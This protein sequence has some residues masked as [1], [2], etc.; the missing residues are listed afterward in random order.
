ML[1]MEMAGP[2][3]VN[4]TSIGV[5]A[6]PFDVTENVMESDVSVVG[7]RPDPLNVI[8][9]GLSGAPSVIVI[10]PVRAPVAEGA[11]VTE[12]EH[13][14]PPASAAPQLLVCVKSLDDT[15]P[16]IAIAVDPLFF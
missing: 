1:A 5:L 8:V 3:L 2:L 4:D 13:V 7:T 6:A 11:N 12:M 15:I 16:P 9:C 10:A 14:A